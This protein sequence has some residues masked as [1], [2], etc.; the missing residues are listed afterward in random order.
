MNLNKQ[1]TYDRR[2]Q[3]QK[4][5]NELLQ[6]AI[7]GFSDYPHCFF[8]FTKTNNPDITKT[9]I[10][11]VKKFVRDKA[12][13]NVSTSQVRNL[14]AKARALT[15]ESDLQLLRPQIAYLMAKQQ[16][17]NDSMKQFFLLL[18][19]LIAKGIQLNDFLKLFEAIVAYHKYYGKKN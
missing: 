15:S 12:A 13:P 16:S 9:T 7:N 19:D 18:D 4:N 2:H 17:Q 3:K 5:D 1:N 6:E 14:Y 8:Q 11:C 10:E